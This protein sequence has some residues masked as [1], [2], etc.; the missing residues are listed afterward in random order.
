MGGVLAMAALLAALL[1]LLLP[2]GGHATRIEVHSCPEGQQPPVSSDASVVSVCSVGEA[3]RWVGA[4]AAAAARERVEVCLHPGAPHVLSEPVYLDRSHSRTTWSSCGGAR[5]VVSGGVAIPSW[6]PARGHE[7]LWAAALPTRLRYLRTLWVNGVRA[8]RTVANAS[9]LLGDL[10]NTSSGY[11]SQRPVPWSTAEA[12]DTVELNY[13]QQ[14]A[15]WQAQRCVV[16]HAS[17]HSLSLAQPCLANL[18]KMILGV[19]G[20]P[21]NRSSGRTGCADSDPGCGG[22]LGNPLGSGLPMWV[23]NIPLTQPGMRSSAGQFWFSRRRQQVYYHP[24]PHEL[25]SDGRRFTAEVVAPVAEGLIVAK[26]LEDVTFEG[27]A[28]QHMAYNQPSTPEGFIDLQ[29][30]LQANSGIP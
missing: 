19:P 20:L 5:A 1:P 6:A 26:D 17:G 24:H 8:N 27:L 14:L 12:E 2:L 25:S 23:E 16:T 29:D 30:G 13:F 21:R 11:V 18:T 28:F 15:P 10:L 7:G 22:L 3:A 9:A 4:A